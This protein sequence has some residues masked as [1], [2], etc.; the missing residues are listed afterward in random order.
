[1][2]P[3][4]PR[5]NPQQQPGQAP[6]PGMA[7]P[8][9][10]QPQARKP[11]PRCWVQNPTPTIVSAKHR[12]TSGSAKL[13]SFNYADE[14]EVTH[15][16][17][18]WLMGHSISTRQ[19]GIFPKSYTQE[20]D[21][22]VEGVTQETLLF[23]EINTTLHQWSL[24]LHHFAS[25][26]H[27]DQFYDLL[28]RAKRLIEYRHTLW[29][30]AESGN[31][32]AVSSAGAAP[33]ISEDERKLIQA[34]A[35]DEMEN[36]VSDFGLDVVVRHNNHEV[37]TLLNTGPSALFGMHM[38]QTEAM[39]KNDDDDSSLGAV[40]LA[41]M[42][43]AKAGSARTQGGAP[44][45]PVVP[46]GGSRMHQIMS[47]KGGRR[48][49]LKGARPPATPGRKEQF[50]VVNSGSSSGSSGN[51]SDQGHGVYY[52]IWVKFV[53]VLLDIQSDFELHFSLYSRS[54]KKFVTEEWVWMFS[55][56]KGVGVQPKNRG[57]QEI[58]DVRIVF[59]NIE[60]TEFTKPD[61]MYL[62]TRVVRVGTLQEESSMAKSSKRGTT[63]PQRFRRP[64][65][66]G[67][68]SLNIDEITADEVETKVDLFTC[69][70][71][72][73]GNLHELLVSG[74][75]DPDIKVQSKSK[76][77]ILT[78]RLFQ[79]SYDELVASNPLIRESDAVDM[80]KVAT[81]VMP[82]TKRNDVYITIDEGDV[83][84]KNVQI[85]CCVR[86]SDQKCKV[87]EG[88]LKCI[89]SC[90]EVPEEGKM[91]ADK[92]YPM[93][94]GASSCKWH[95]TFKV[96][97]PDD[98]FLPECHIFFELHHVSSDGKIGKPFAFS[99]L[100][101]SE[102]NQIMK[103]GVHSIPLYKWHHK[104]EFLTPYLEDPSKKEIK[105]A[106]LKVSATISS[107]KYTQDE[108]LNRLFNWESQPSAISDILR[109]VTFINSQDIV[110]HLEKVFK[111][112][113]KMLQM[114]KDNDTLLDQIYDNIARILDGLTEQH[115]AWNFRPALD[116]YITKFY[117]D[118]TPQ[119]L[120]S[121]VQKALNS[122]QTAIQ[123][124]IP[125]LSKKAEDK[126][127]IIAF[128]KTEDTLI[129]AIKSV[130]T[131]T[132]VLDYLWM[133]IIQSHR[134]HCSA[135]F[136]VV[137]ADPGFRNSLIGFLVSYRSLLS[138]P[139]SKLTVKTRGQTVRVLIN[140]MKHFPTIMHSMAMYFKPEE[141]CGEIVH[142]LDIVSKMV[143]QVSPDA[144]SPAKDGKSKESSINSVA[145]D[146]FKIT[147]ARL[148]LYSSI[149]SGDFFRNAEIRTILLPHL[150]RFI[151][152]QMSTSLN[153]LKAL[154][155]AELD[156]MDT[157][158][159]AVAAAGD[160]SQS[161]KSKR[162][163]ECLKCVEIIGTCVDILQVHASLQ[164]R[165]KSV[166]LLLCTLLLILDFSDYVN[167]VYT[168]RRDL[169]SVNLEALQLTSGEA[170]VALMK[171]EL[172]SVEGKQDRRRMASLKEDLFVMT[173]V[174]ALIRL[175]TPDDWEAFISRAIDK[176]SD[177]IIFLTKLF[178]YII[179]CY[180]THSFPK[181]WGTMVG[182][183][184]STIL[185]FVRTLEASRWFREKAN[186]FNGMPIPPEN[187]Q[188][189][190]DPK[191]T[192]ARKC[193]NDL[194]E[195]WLYFF[196]M[197]MKYLKSPSLAKEKLSLLFLERYG[198]LRNP[199]CVVMR[200]TWKFFNKKFFLFQEVI[201]NFLMLIDMQH[202]MIRTNALEC[203][204][205]TLTFDLEMNKNMDMVKQLTMEM[206][207]K[208][209][210][211]DSF[212]S[213]FFEQLQSKVNNLPQLKAQNPIDDLRT[214][215]YT[216]QKLKTIPKNTDMLDTRM[217][218]MHDMLDF[219][220]ERGYTELYERFVGQ[221]YR[222]FD[223]Y[224][225]N[226]SYGH[227]LLL[228]ANLFKWEDHR[229]LASCSSE[230]RLLPPAI[231]EAQPACSRRE[232]L[233]VMAAEKL[234]EGKEYDTA[235][236]TLQEAKEFNAEQ[237]YDFDEV[238]SILSAQAFICKE[239]EAQEEAIPPEYYRV[240]FFG[241]DAEESIRNKEFVY[242]AHPLEKLGDFQERLEKQYPGC[243]FLKKTD[244]PTAEVTETPGLK[245]LVTP[246]KASSLEEAEPEHAK[247][248]QSIDPANPTVLP[249]KVYAPMPSTSIFLY[250]KPFRKT[251]RQ[252]DEN[253]FVGLYLQKLF[254]YVKDGFPSSRCRSVVTKR[255]EIEVSPLQNA[256]SSVVDKTAELKSI[257]EKHKAHP[258]L[259]PQPLIMLVNG[260]I[261][262]AVNGGTWMYKEAFLGEDYRKAHPEDV[263]QCDKLL[264]SIIEQIKALDGG[265]ETLDKLCHMEQNSS[266][267]SLFEVMKLQQSDSRK[268]WIP[269]EAPAADT[270]PVSE[271]QTPSAQAPPTQAAQSAPPP[272]LPAAAALAATPATPSPAAA[273]TSVSR[274]DSFNTPRPE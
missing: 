43:E 122:I 12:F 197:T 116:D 1:M 42:M 19:P 262:A 188:P 89:L 243:E 8:L 21:A 272:S 53:M 268:K 55:N 101:L 155:A 3:V 98:L 171:Q 94:M 127:A 135:N 11:P 136:L 174:I 78:T 109:R 9:P 230:I 72:Q 172:E 10:G 34:K 104:G 5:V 166:Y 84:D 35:M 137:D 114:N 225:D 233:F 33:Q 201:R 241:S 245:I 232:K 115:A 207:E 148:A 66:A 182:F 190:E 28:Q 244:Y 91:L 95:E 103:E 99:F 222:L 160:D 213:F 206:K 139:L 124:A 265:M 90:D 240:G 17:N 271:P 30:D 108:S 39:S 6:K 112:L 270:T 16:C 216:V 156:T 85:M 257:I 204:V 80:M 2:Q 229:Q 246:V 263:S 273:E 238:C 29:P 126:E 41:M 191:I 68:T 186:T 251:P 256:I 267:L 248:P 175:M 260:I 274:T 164:E 149:V 152:I 181:G 46:G 47:D 105:S 239:L 132:K 32:A 226:R 54:T 87:Q 261:C 163:R 252:K 211:K 224:K 199:M 93:V 193:F 133:I 176:D 178:K 52:Q 117:K 187:P 76:G 184:Y 236:A 45:T 96:C 128:K 64:F 158:G 192:E 218:A 202:D 254:L 177:R 227:S 58:T 219:L 220:K 79:T 250:S 31:P 145:L 22:D 77:I 255:V 15:E 14:L 143:I 141:L 118:S 97:P 57:K 215:F 214:F 130:E 125:G 247:K 81:L 134:N 123:T 221:L 131:T 65:G 4:Q 37:A 51:I 120:L 150:S 208:D 231:T 82:G 194:K 217:S 259:N 223:D 56:T 27:P 147:E 235:Y 129:K 157:T 70:D 165:K 73:F 102:K 71:N 162:I 237:E 142:V 168:N 169:T 264:E 138:V 38:E 75:I 266:M 107:T 59:K 113:F 23:D 258:E 110:R 180:G 249:D 212:E 69:S 88:G 25:A 121:L 198:D 185:K 196:D 36:A 269:E 13:V 49:K 203:Y 86:N 92:F 151:Q 153:N 144:A 63:E 189:G 50:S 7:R 106:H 62:V 146:T 48:S 18:G 111:E 209:C 119:P 154:G 183:E 60:S 200:R 40:Q 173:V 67:A 195:L 100:R 179:R 44:A 20:C 161:E 159:L 170:V 167:K 74:S 61:D 234:E 26:H 228:H 253:E 205:M 24:L 242:L 83:N 140:A 210:F